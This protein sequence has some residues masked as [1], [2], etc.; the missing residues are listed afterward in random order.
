MVREWP[1]AL[2]MIRQ[3]KY[4]RKNRMAAALAQNLIASNWVSRDIRAIC[5]SPENFATVGRQ[6]GATLHE[7]EAPANM[8]QGGAQSAVE[9]GG[10]ELDVLEIM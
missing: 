6:G 8:V 7:S 5:V 10:I 9:F 2:E 3:F 1:P 4:E